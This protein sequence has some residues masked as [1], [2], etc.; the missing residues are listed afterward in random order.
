[1]KG[2]HCQFPL[3]LEKVTLKALNLNV[4]LNVNLKLKYK[5]RRKHT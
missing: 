4:N 5:K 3:S 1:M 2:T